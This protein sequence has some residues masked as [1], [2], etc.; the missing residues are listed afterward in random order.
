MGIIILIVWFFT[1]RYRNLTAN[2]P[3]TGF[4]E[5]WANLKKIKNIRP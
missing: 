2:H 4:D 1:L 5:I 3:Q